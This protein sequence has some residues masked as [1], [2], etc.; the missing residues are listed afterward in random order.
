MSLNFLAILV[1]AVIPMALGMIWYN[2][3]VLGTAWMNASGMTEEKAKT[4]NM[5]LVFGLS[6]FFSF[7]LAFEMQFLVI[8][9]YHIVSAF[10]DYKEQIKD[11]ATPEGALFKQVMDLVGMGH[12]T[13]GHGALHGTIAGIAIA[14]PIT[15]VNALFEAKSMKYIFINAGFWIVSM[16]LM[17]GILSVWM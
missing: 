3:K 11:V 10:F 12:R 1:A 6:F 13:F 7:L 2:P 14:L 15:G 5:G 4:A 9:Q 17:G 8:H 16:A